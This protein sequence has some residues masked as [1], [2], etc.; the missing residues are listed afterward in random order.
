MRSSIG[1]VTIA[2][3]TTLAG[4]FAPADS[5]AWGP[6]GH[7]M[8]AETAAILLEKELPKTW[9]PL[10]ARHRFEMGYYAILPDSLFRHADGNKGQLEAP[11]HFLDLDLIAGTEQMTPAAKKK[12]A[13]I[14]LEWEKAKAHFATV[15]G[16]DKVS[17]VGSVPWRVEQ[18][19]D[20][21]WKSFKDLKAVKGGYQRGEES[22]ADTKKIYQGLYYLGVLSHYTGDASMPYHATSDWNG[23]KTGQGGI[24][25]YFESDCVNELEPGL[26]KDVLDE[27]L[28]M[29][30]KWLKEWNASTER[31]AGVMIKVLMDSAN[32]LDRLRKIDKTKAIVAPSDE[33]KKTFAKRKPTAEGCKPMRAMLVEHIAKGS[34]LTAYVWGKVLPAGVDFS[35]G[36]SLQFSD[37][38]WHPAYIEPTYENSEFLLKLAAP[39]KDD[40]H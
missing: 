2:T 24:H 19:Q 27:A 37:F 39:I 11:T 21:A 29:R 35:K 8:V 20:L 5:R 12:I 9:G 36:G 33:A 1:T 26:S 38:D 18:L 17:G 13:A 10:L 30:G 15:V 28:R 6:L 22:D 3:L 4:V 34:V 16:E 31:P 25:F 23:W 32:A 7:R 14:P 40:D